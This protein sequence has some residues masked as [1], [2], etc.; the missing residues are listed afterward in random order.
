MIELEKMHVLTM[1]N[2]HN[3]VTHRIIKILSIPH[4]AYIVP[5]DQNKFVFYVNNY[6]D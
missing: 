5:E 2:S 1:E 4:N 6:I 3:L